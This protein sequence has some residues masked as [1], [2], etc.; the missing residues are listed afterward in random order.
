MFL[1]TVFL[2]SSYLIVQSN[3]KRNTDMKVNK[4]GKL[5]TFPVKRGDYNYD[6]L[7]PAKAWKTIVPLINLYKSKKISPGDSILFKACEKWTINGFQFDSLGGKQNKYIVFSSYGHC[8]L[9]IFSVK[10]AKNSFL[11][12]NRCNFIKKKSRNRR[13]LLWT[14]YYLLSQYIL[15]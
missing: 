5:I 3:N 15:K 12:L 4:A 14:K 2:F 8:A 10:G 13:L 1:L 7:S 6:G 11:F 9:P